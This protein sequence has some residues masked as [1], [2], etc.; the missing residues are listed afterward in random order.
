MCL[1]AGIASA[2][3]VA[4][5]MDMDLVGVLMFVLVFVFDLWLHLGWCPHLDGCLCL[6]SGVVHGC[7][8]GHHGYVVYGCGQNMGCGDGQRIDNGG[9]K[10]EDR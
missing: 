2:H 10:K 8:G 3:V 9:M 6:H 7:I 1:L 4:G 5:F